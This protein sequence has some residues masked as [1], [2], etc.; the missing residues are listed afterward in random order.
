[1]SVAIHWP[2]PRAGSFGLPRNGRR[3]RTHHR[4]EETTGAVMAGLRAVIE[5]N[6]TEM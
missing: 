6:V 4:E 1:M 2:P 3:C 5:Q